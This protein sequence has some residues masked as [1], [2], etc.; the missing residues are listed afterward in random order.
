MHST[1]KQKKKTGHRMRSMK[2]FHQKNLNLPEYNSF[3]L[4]V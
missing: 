2:H 1:Y 4:D 3:L